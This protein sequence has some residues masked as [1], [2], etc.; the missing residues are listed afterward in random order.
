M[1]L[2]TIEGAL[3]FAQLLTN[4]RSCYKEIKRNAIK[5]KRLSGGE[6]VESLEQLCAYIRYAEAIAKRLNALTIQET[7]ATA[8]NVNNQIKALKITDQKQIN[9][10]QALYSL[11]DRLLRMLEAVDR[12]NFIENRK[13]GDLIRLDRGAIDQVKAIKYNALQTATRMK[14]ANDNISQQYRKA[15]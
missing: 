5:V 6:K 7:L 2:N 4:F 15:A 10:I 9:Q 8:Q 11:F 14:A 12:D 13:S 1:D 3:S